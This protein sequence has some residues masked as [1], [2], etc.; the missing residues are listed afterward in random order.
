MRP[1]IIPVLLV[2]DQGLVKTVKFSNGK[3][4]GDPINAINL[5]NEMEVDELIVMDISATR[6]G[7]G[8]DLCLIEECCGE[9]FMPIGYV[10]GVTSVSQYERLFN[11]GV[12]KIGINSAF[13]KNP[14]LI[15]EASR[16]FG[17][18]SVVAVIDVKKT[19]MGKYKVYDYSTG[20]TEATDLQEHLDHIQHLGAGEI[21]IYSVDQDGTMGGYDLQLVSEISK[22]VS[23]PLVICGGADSI[24]SMVEVIKHGADAAA[25][26]SIFVYSR[27]KTK[28]VLINYPTQEELIEA[29]GEVR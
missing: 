24:S 2:Q 3:Y 16:L 23:V 9:A 14:E 6:Q 8:P 5:F 25:A 11:I 19:L 26:G 1:R 15:Q 7:R 27:T 4:I 17:S 13:R 22:S 28:G 12:E 18:Q 29:F 10:G 21:V 20:K